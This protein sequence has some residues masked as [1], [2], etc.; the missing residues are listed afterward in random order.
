MELIT[1]ATS[2]AIPVN[3]A[4][5]PRARRHKSPQGLDC[6]VWYRTDA[7]S[8]T[9]FLARS[10]ATRDSKRGSDAQSNGQLC[11]LPIA[12]STTAPGA[13]NVLAPTPDPNRPPDQVCDARHPHSGFQLPRRLQ[14]TGLLEQLSEQF[15]SIRLSSLR[16]ARR[17]LATPL[18][19]AQQFRRYSALP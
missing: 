18:N 11:K 5:T 3:S 13:H 16:H 4:T 10:N 19:A 12:V 7:I 9:E 8:L 17:E 6:Q 1:I 2:N 15:V 14:W